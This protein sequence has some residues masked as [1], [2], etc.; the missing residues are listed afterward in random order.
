MQEIAKWR[1]AAEAAI[2]VNLARR[3]LARLRWRDPLAGRVELS[4][5]D[6]VVAAFAGAG[7]TL[8]PRLLPGKRGVR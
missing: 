4:K 6:F 1:L 2:I 8:L 5:G 3:L 7:R